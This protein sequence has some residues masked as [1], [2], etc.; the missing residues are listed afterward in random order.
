[1]SYYKMSKI[2][3]LILAVVHAYTITG[4]IDRKNTKIDFS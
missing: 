1:M 2:I 3:S 4:V